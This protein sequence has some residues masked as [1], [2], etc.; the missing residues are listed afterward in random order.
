[1]K[2]I[3]TALVV[4]LTAFSMS[5]SAVL[6]PDWMED[7]QSGDRQTQASYNVVK[8]FAEDDFTPTTLSSSLFFGEWDGTDDLGRN[9]MFL[10]P[11][12]GGF[13][14]QT[15]STSIG[16]DQIAS[17]DRQ[18]LGQ[19]ATAAIIE[20]P[21]CEWDPENPDTGEGTKI[22]ISKDQFAKFSGAI[23]G[24]PALIQGYDMNGDGFPDDH[25]TGQHEIQWVGWQDPSW[26]TTYSDCAVV[27][28]SDVQL[29]ES[30]NA[31]TVTISADSGGFIGVEDEDGNIVPNNIFQLI[32]AGCDGSDGPFS[33][34]N[35]IWQGFGDPSKSPNYPVVQPPLAA[36]YANQDLLAED[37][38]V[39]DSGTELADLLPYVDVIEPGSMA[40]L[41]ELGSTMHSDVS[42]TEICR[43]GV[44]GQDTTYLM[45]GS[46]G[47]TGA[48]ENACLDPG[49]ELSID[50]SKLD[51]DGEDGEVD[52]G[53]FNY[54][55]TQGMVM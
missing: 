36:S 55:F 10:L 19:S 26:T 23:V 46:A 4:L 43:N 12:S 16:G 32:D 24:A 5:A 49:V 2:K 38:T 34:H 52:G 22:G 40:Q 33:G 42:L 9:S 21:E 30:V 27:G 14:E 7:L 37:G 41:T 51:F 28:T 20:V 31:A 48:F 53:Q 8:G 29:H 45:S 18:Y 11:D 13:I 44:C 6:M 50:M 54:W 3:L 17:V 15:L 47:L 1:M 35:E 25:Y 39:T